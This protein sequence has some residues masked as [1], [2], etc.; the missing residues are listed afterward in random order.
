MDRTELEIQAE[1]VYPM[2]LNPCKWTICKVTWLRV[3]WVDAKL[4]SREVK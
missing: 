3:Q 2:P 1:Q 4:Y